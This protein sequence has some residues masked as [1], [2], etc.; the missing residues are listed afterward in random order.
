MLRVEDVFKQY[1][2][3]P[4]LENIRLEVAPGEILTVLGPSGCGKTTLLRVIAGF[5]MPERGRIWLDGVEVSSPRVKIPPHQRK[6]SMIFQDLA[7]WPHMTVEASLRFVLKNRHLPETDIA[8]QVA[9]MLKLVNL[10]G[11]ER[12]YP[13]ALSGGE[14][15]RLA[16]AR[17]FV[18]SPAYLL[19]DE[20]FS[21]LDHL[22]IAD[23]IQ[24]LLEYKERWQ[25]GILYVSHNIEEALALS[26]KLAILKN[27]RLQQ[28][29][30]ADE[31]LSNPSNEFVKRFLKV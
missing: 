21:D 5:E 7:L 2:A 18:S 19:M 6:L 8:A 16:I 26:D 20:P 4:V 28:L 10:R 9:A 1:D 27:G 25:T 15:Q 11:Y 24:V 23:L 12:R 17:A 31:V 3:A 29:G 14:K 22:L 13:H 30:D